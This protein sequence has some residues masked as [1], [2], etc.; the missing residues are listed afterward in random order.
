MCPE[1]PIVSLKPGLLRALWNFFED[2]PRSPIDSSSRGWSALPSTKSLPCPGAIHDN[3]N[4]NVAAEE[5]AKTNLFLF[6][7]QS[8]TQGNIL[9]LVLFLTQCVCST[10]HFWMYLS[11]YVGSNRCTSQQPEEW[12]PHIFPHSLWRNKGNYETIY[13]GIVALYMRWF[14]FWIY[15]NDMFISL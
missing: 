13:I 15:G 14:V 4:V 9:C 3:R 1:I 5:K 2:S 11:R 6:S 8:Y 10:R 7:Q 12:Q